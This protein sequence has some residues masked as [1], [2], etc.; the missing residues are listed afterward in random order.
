MTHARKQIRDA[1]YTALDATA[2]TTFNGR[3]F[4]L[5]NN[6]LPAFS[7]FGREEAISAD[8]NDG[9]LIGI[10]QR[11][12]IIAVQGY[13]KVEASVDDELDALAEL[14][15]QIIFKDAAIDALVRC[16][17]L[18]ATEIEVSPD[19]ENKIGVITLNFSC[20]YMTNDGE[21]EVTI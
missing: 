17:D 4:P 8:N 18:V 15:E 6:I 5:H 7:V 21:P 12:A 9:R 10:Q 16:L 1:F 2:I 3:V 19:G 11:T 13:A 14:C 20:R